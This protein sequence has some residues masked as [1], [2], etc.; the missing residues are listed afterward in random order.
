MCSLGLRDSVDLPFPLI[1]VGDPCL[2]LRPLALREEGILEL[3]LYSSLSV[4]RVA[5]HRI[6]AHP[7]RIETLNRMNNCVCHYTQWAYALEQL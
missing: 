6:L 1:R 3:R 2:G 7:L 5:M 4:G